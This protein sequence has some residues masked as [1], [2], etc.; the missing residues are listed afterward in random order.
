MTIYDMMLIIYDIASL[1]EY[2]FDIQPTWVN[3]IFLSNE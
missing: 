3:A 2:L 1:S